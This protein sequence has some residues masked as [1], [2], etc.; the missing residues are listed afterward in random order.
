MP[1]GS[2]QRV[3]VVVGNAEVV[4]RTG[5][6]LACGFL[7]P[8]KSLV[9]IALHAVAG[10]V[11]NAKLVLRGGIAG[12]CLGNQLIHVCGKGRQG[13]ECEEK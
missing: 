2:A 9:R 3:A 7:E 13:N 11:L 8:C 12:V 6:P 4:H 5:V 10:A 1:S